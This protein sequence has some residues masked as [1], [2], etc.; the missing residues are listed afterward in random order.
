MEI[1]E[2]C[3]L[4]GAGRGFELVVAFVDVV[5]LHIIRLG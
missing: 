4:R 1:T 2:L 5:L 3:A